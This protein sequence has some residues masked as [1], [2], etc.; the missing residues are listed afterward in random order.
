MSEETTLSNYLTTGDEH[1]APRVGLSAAAWGLYTHHYGAESVANRINRMVEL[2]AAKH[3]ERLD[4]EEEVLD[5]MDDYD[6]WGATELMPVS[7]LGAVLDLL[8]ERHTQ[9]QSV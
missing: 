5:F 9:A 6:D 2:A 4:A 3:S 7:Q 8:Y 1:T